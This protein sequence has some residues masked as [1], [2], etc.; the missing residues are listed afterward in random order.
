[1]TEPDLLILGAGPAG[2]CAALAAREAGLETVVVDANPAPGGQVYRAAPAS[3]RIH[4]HNPDRRNGE[5]LRTALAGSGAVVASGH[6]VWSV[7]RDLRVDA[8]GPDGPVHWRP[9]AL[10]V[11]AGTSERV[12][13]FPGWTLPGVMGLAAATILL[14][15]QAMLP[16]R[17]TV[18]AGCGPLLAAVAH[19]ILKAG[20]EVAAVVDLASRR[21]WAVRLPAL[22]ARPGDLARGLGWRL[23]TTLARVPWRYRHGVRRAMREGDALTVEIGPVDGDGAPLDG[24]TTT[25]RADA[26][27]VG[28]GLTPAT[29]VLRLLGAR[30]EYRREA[31]GWVPVLDADQR[32]SV[33]GLYAAGDGCGVMGAAAAQQAGWLAG[34]TAARDLGRL[35]PDRYRLWT[36]P[37]RHRLARMRR[38]GRAMAGLL[39]LRPGQ[40]AAIPADT[41]VCRCEEITRTEIEAALACGVRDVNT[42][43][44]WTRCGMG[45]CQ[46]RMCGETVAALVATRAGSRERAGIWTAR[47]PLRP[48]DLAALTGEY[49]YAD[50]GIPEA[51]PL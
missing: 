44:S 9:R 1:M 17:R 39:A 11:A 6:T 24:P 22:A 50:I 40:V 27:V 2:I 4:D 49:E 48:V 26:L 41:V 16:G 25:L 15:S 8:V 14:K 45:P 7:G 30:H 23:R 42:L 21:D 5:R 51:A 36:A 46:G 47:V 10:V 29:E 28:H 38:A 35:A 32:T 37:H 20:G 43:K 12:V 3:F 18:V 33:A 31:G 13:P 34:F 19:G